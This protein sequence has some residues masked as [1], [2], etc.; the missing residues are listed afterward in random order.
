MRRSEFSNERLFI[1]RD[2]AH[3]PVIH[4]GN[5]AAARALLTH[6]SKLYKTCEKM[7][8]FQNKTWDY[9]EIHLVTF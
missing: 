1:V 5:S 2:L 4:F 3:I 9:E 8:S 6:F 7:L